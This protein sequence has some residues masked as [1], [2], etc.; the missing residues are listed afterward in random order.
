MPLAETRASFAAHLGSRLRLS[1][2]D[3]YAVA[4]LIA[5]VEPVRSRVDIVRQGEPTEWFVLLLDGY[6]CRY[7]VGSLGQRQILSFHFPGE[8]LEAHATARRPTTAWH[9]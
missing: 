7:K 5:R 8:I 4:S 2:D 6:T 3:A 9:H 1:V